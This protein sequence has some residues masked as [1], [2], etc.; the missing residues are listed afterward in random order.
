MAVTLR[1]TARRGH[2]QHILIAAAL[3]A[4]VI[5]VMPIAFAI[6]GGLAPVGGPL[7]AFASAPPGDYAVVARTEGDI[8]VIAVAAVN[9]P[10]NATEVAR[11]RHL[12]GFSTKGAVSPDGK[13]IA[14]VAPDSGTSSQPSASLLLIEMEAGTQAQLARGI[15]PQAAPLWARDG[16]AVVVTRSLGSASGSGVVRFVRVRVD[17][18]GEEILSEY[19]GVLGAY[20]IGFDPQGRFLA[21]V[22]DGRGST[23]FRDSAEVLL[24]SSQITRDWRLSPDG[25]QVAFIESNLDGGLHYQARLQA[26]DGSG[27]GASAQGLGDGTQQLGVA[28]RPGAGGPTFGS[29]SAIVSPVSA[30]ALTAASALSDGVTGGGGFDVPLGYSDDGEALAVNHWTGTGFAQAGKAS[31]QVVTDGGRVEL[32]GFATFLGWA[33]R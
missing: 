4:A 30:Q 17:G 5:A 33:A 25:T 24:L 15:D 9:D 8:D 18:A 3:A 28:W 26:L 12:P 10:L 29:E 20:G 6:L 21:V 31:L 22:I 32:A 13:R 19:A 27:S 16:S 11:V 14:I 7:T 1:A 23:L 2:F